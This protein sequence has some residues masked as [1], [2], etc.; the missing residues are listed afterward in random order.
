M[1]LIKDL[2]NKYKEIIMSLVMGFATTIVSWVTYALFEKMFHDS[3]Q[4]VL[5]ASTLSWICSVIFA[6]IT[7]KLFVFESYSW[8]PAFIAKEL[9]LFVS[10]RFATGVFEI[11]SIT[12]LVDVLKF[13]PPVFKTKGMVAK[14]IV[15]I[16][17]V[18]LNYI[19]S[20]LLIFKKDDIAKSQTTADT[21]QK[22]IVEE[23]V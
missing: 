23:T 9:S 14:I 20:K 5:I 8:N 21:V 10:T 22:K 18:I 3:N 1:N 15:S 19:F 16:I 4:A 17:V 13:D 11:A 7:N 12:L 2:F 6:Y